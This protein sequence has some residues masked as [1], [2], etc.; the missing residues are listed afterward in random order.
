[1]LPPKKKKRQYAGEYLSE[2]IS[3]KSPIVST[4]VNSK[5]P[6]QN[7]EKQPKVSIDNNVADEIPSVVL[8]EKQLSSNADDIMNLRED[9]AKLK[10]LICYFVFIL[11]ILVLFC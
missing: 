8:N 9:L 6:P 1:M 5:I 11:V 2:K 3:I 10:D 7:L 4:K